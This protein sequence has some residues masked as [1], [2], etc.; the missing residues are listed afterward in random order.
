MMRKQWHYMFTIS[1]PDHGYWKELASPI[2][3]HKG[4]IIKIGEIIYEVTEKSLYKCGTI[5]GLVIEKRGGIQVIVKRE[6]ETWGGPDY[7][8]LFIRG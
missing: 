4:S 8:E 7:D 5:S 1:G 6:H 3:L 2:E